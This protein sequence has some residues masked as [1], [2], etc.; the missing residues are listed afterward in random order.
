MVFSSPAAVILEF[1]SFDFGDEIKELEFKVSYPG[2]VVAQ[3]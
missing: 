1:P 2:I 3:R